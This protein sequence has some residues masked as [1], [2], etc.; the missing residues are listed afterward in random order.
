MVQHPEQQL[1]GQ[2]TAVVGANVSLCREHYRLVL[3]LP[4]FPRTEPGQ[5]L[6]LCCADPEAVTETRELNWMDGERPEPGGHEL[7]EPQAFLRRPFS[8]AGRRDR[9]GAGVELDFIHRVVGLGTNWL[10][11]LRVGDRVGLLGPLGNR[12]VLP[13]KDEIALMVGGGVGIPPMIYLAERLAGRAAVAF[14]G[15]LTRDLLPLTIDP[16]VGSPGADGAEPLMSIGEFARHGIPAVISTDDGS[17]GFRGFVTQALEKFLDAPASLTRAGKALRPVIYT[18]GPEPMMKRV[19]R[20]ASDRGIECQV[21]VERAMAC[22]MG[23]CQSCCIKVAK[24]DPAKPPLAGKDW[25]WRLACTD[26]PIFR[27]SELLW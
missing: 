16:V 23:T 3:R 14:S 15:A 24:P 5:F 12:F 22:G 2:F 20:I 1:R 11:R 17:Y 7:M 8:L 19:A 25:C 26:G 18:C 13:E 10:S 6:Q 9:S 27:G 21:A 4:E